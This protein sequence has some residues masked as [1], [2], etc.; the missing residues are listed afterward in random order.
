MYTWLYHNL[1]F[2]SLNLKW[3]CT[4]IKLWGDKTCFIF[5]VSRFYTLNTRIL[6]TCLRVTLLRNHVMSN[7][8]CL[9]NKSSAVLSFY[10]LDR[11][12]LKSGCFVLLKWCILSCTAEENLEIFEL[13]GEWCC[14]LVR[15]AH[16]CTW[17]RQTYNSLQWKIS[18]Y[19]SHSTNMRSMSQ[20][21]AIKSPPVIVVFWEH[22]N[23][24]F[25]CV[26]K[27]NRVC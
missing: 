11:Q 18:Y 25:H 2:H 27:C 4:S 12:L 21:L 26:F 8:H 17:L 24:C 1:Q 16:R 5:Y 3:I 7:V 13:M 23:R 19:I 14:V 22:N 20:K 15:R 6:Y 9:H 10:L